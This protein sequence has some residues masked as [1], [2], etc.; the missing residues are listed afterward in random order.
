MMMRSKMFETNDLAMC[1][2]QGGVCPT[3]VAKL[4]TFN[5]SHHHDFIKDDIST[6]LL[7]ALL[8]DGFMMMRKELRTRVAS[9]MFVKHRKQTLVCQT[10]TPK[11]DIFAKSH[12]HDFINLFR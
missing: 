2:T 3:Q 5:Q 11:L 1:V 9:M 7:K 6:K 12:H 10:S 8:K 4:D